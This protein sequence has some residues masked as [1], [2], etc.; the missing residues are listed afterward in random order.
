MAV[1][2]TF[3]ADFR[4]FTDAVKAAEV[5]LSDLESGAGK[6]DKALT[7][8]VE[9]FSGK[10]IIADA[11]L[12]TKAIGDIENVTK[13][14]ANEQQKLNTILQEATAKYKALGLQAP[15]D[16]QALADTTKKA[17]DETKK[18]ESGIAALGG[19][20]T[21]L[22]GALGIGFSVGAVVAFGKSVFDSA[23]QI[24]DLA[25]QLGISTDAVQG[26]KFAAE[27]SGSTL[28]A[29]GTAITKMNQNLAGGDK[30]TVQALKDAGLNF[31][32]IRNMKPEDAFLAITDA[33][34]QIPDPMTQSDIA[35]QL[36]GKSA[37]QLLPAI[38]EGFRGT[39]SAASK[40]SEDTIGSLKQAQD[41]WNA[42]GT[43]V[44]NVTGT[45]I[46]TAINGTKNLAGSLSGFT[47]FLENTIR[48]GGPA[49]LALASAQE[50]MAKAS[51]K[52]TDAQPPLTN[53][54]HKTAEE[55]AAEEAA[56]KKAADAIAAHAAAIQALAD[57][58]SGAA[59]AKQVNDLS[60]AMKKLG[61]SANFQQLADDIGKLFKEGANLTPQMLQLGI[62]FGTL[63]PPMITVQQAFKD[64]AATIDV[65]P[66]KIDKVWEELNKP[67]PFGITQLKNE[68]A[69]LVV[70]SPETMLK[71]VAVQAHDVNKALGELS[72]SFSELAQIAGGSLGDVV[73]GMGTLISSLET[74]NKSL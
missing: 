55:L 48:V 1:T 67:I 3:K 34:Q 52:A 42:F 13:L 40:M 51:A 16:M 17:V 58:Y 18:A 20:I 38:K 46:A 41:A 37:G 39:A 6:V 24:G 56:A 25:S 4:S 47:M 32:A 33:I 61:P 7:K 74:T 62:A 29:V 70:I 68:F 2:A 10:K 28:D 64:L 27:Q 35:L 53:A 19:G 43:S 22:A 44:T 72:Q 14:T 9:G 21:K 23:S 50:Q 57:K 12:A 63:T 8:M 54:V 36:F 69:A 45:A 65:V 59:I 73:R 71:G 31:Q 15:A 5:Q 11:T 66:P 60:E 49:A 30:A 26:F